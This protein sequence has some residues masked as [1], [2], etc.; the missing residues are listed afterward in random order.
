MSCGLQKSGSE[1]MMVDTVSQNVGQDIKPKGLSGPL[2]PDIGVVAFVP[3]EWGG[4]WISAWSRLSII[5]RNIRV[6]VL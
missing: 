5:Q 3:E 6:N 1:S 4:P 2:F